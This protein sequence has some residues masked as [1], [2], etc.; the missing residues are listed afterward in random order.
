MIKVEGL[1]KH[2]GQ[3]IAI[4][5]LTF[6]ADKGEIVGFLGPNGAGKTTTMRILT[7]YMPATTGSVNIAGF[8]I[9]KE[10]LE[11][12]RH[13]G[14]LPENVPLYED[15]K[16]WQYLDY[17][18]DLRSVPNRGERVEAVMGL[19][20][21]T[22]RAES[23][24]SSLSKGMRQRVGLAQ[25]ILHQP[26]VLILDEPTV[27]LDPIQKRDVL[28]LI[29]ELGKDCTVLFS[30]HILSEAQAICN[31]LLIINNGQIVAEDSPEKLQRRMTGG[32]RVKVSVAGD[33][34]GL[35]Q[36]FKGLS[37]LDGIRSVS[38][39]SFELDLPGGGK[40]MRPAIARLVV[41]N[42]YE[43]L[44]LRSMDLNLEQIYLQLIRSDAEAG[45]H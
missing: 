7:G 37:W 19:V 16:V 26:K 39:N 8:D 43:L 38:G 23:F 20:G 44:E 28:E 22:D 13:I 24:I 34:D 40:D 25:A 3:R 2:Y 5:D 12:R 42:G 6:H 21:M 35:M 11:A 1:S 14:Y 9:F 36:L 41:E 27:G 45:A 17:L 31:R 33:A 10:S 15:M 30:T 18:G 29:R 4:N 32:E